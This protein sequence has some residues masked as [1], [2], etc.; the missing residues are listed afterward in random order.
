MYSVK[1]GKI[2]ILQLEVFYEILISTILERE[3]LE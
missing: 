3:L 1:R 2:I